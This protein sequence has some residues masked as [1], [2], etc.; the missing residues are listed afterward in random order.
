MLIL[1][2]PLVDAKTIEQVQEGVAAFK[3]KHGADALAKAYD[4]MNYA[5]RPDRYRKT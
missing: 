3:E 1:G 4:Q 5:N 2:V